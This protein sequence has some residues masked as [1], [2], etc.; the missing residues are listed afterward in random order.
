MSISGTFESAGTVPGECA[1]IGNGDAYHSGTASSSIS[2]STVRPWRMED[3][4]GGSLDVPG[5]FPRLISTTNGGMVLRSTETRAST[6]HFCP[7]DST[8]PPPNQCGTRTARGSLQ[9][10]PI[11]VGRRRTQFETDFSVSA[12]WYDIDYP[13]DGDACPL[14]QA[15]QAFVFPRHEGGFGVVSG[16]LG[17]VVRTARIIGHRRFVLR[18]SF[19]GRSVA[20]DG[21]TATYR[22]A[23]R[24]TFVRQPLI[25][26]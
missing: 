20:G 24:L 16:G 12:D 14:A 19:H 6:I 5:N 7:A 10:D 25:S 22:F 26:R 21:S 23:Y 11:P 9:G 17:P 4:K 18:K 8:E 13:G 2:F 3:V 1:D 15:Q